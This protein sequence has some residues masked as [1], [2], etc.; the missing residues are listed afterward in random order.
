MLR[1]MIHPSPGRKIIEKDYKMI[2]VD[3]AGCIYPDDAWLHYCVNWKTA[4]MHRDCSA[5][6]LKQSVDQFLALERAKDIR[7]EGKNKWVFPNI[8]GSG[9]RKM[10]ENLWH[11]FLEIPL[12]NDSWVIVDSP[13]FVDTDVAGKLVLFGEV[14]YFYKLDCPKSGGKVRLG[15]CQ[16]RACKRKTLVCHSFSPS[17]RRSASTRFS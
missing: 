10:S 12:R 15:Q 2:E 7:Q 5:E 8:Y 3:V 9:Y 17:W 11:S 6:I 13:M 14:V 16:L 4:D 1:S